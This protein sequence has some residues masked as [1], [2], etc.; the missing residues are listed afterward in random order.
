VIVLNWNGKRNTYE[1]LESLKRVDYSR[2]EVIVVD[3]DSFDGSQE[4]F[5][6]N[7]PSITLIENKENIGFGAG[8]N[9]GIAEAIN[10][11]ADYI[12]CL[13]NDIVV[14]QNILRELVKIGE[15]DPA[16]GGLSPKEYFFHDPDRINFA[17]GVMKLAGCKIF[18][19]GKLDRGQYNRIVETTLL[20]GPAMFLKTNALQDI[21]FFDESYFY[22]PED[23]DIAMRLADK[24][25]RL[26]FVPR[27]KLWH[28]GRGATGGS[29]TPLT[30]YFQV[31]NYLLF[32]KKHANNLERFFSVLYLG[33]LEFPLLILKGFIGHRRQYI[34]AAINGILW[35]LSPASV[36]S[37]MKMVQLL[38]HVEN[39]I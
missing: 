16:I 14:D 3:N 11:R 33:L 29:V 26:L 22:G 17:G 23:K 4:F 12:F 15:L 19:H 27:A 25:Y 35:N 28:K 38:S 1:C 20:S 18:G 32:A 36:P 30:V 7:F 10:C 9:K 21:G 34:G 31:R 6:K 13:N 8:F 5:K 2:Y 39:D 37:D 24:G